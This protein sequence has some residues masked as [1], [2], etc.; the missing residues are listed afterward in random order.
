MTVNNHVLKC[1]GKIYSFGYRYAAVKVACRISC[2][3][4]HFTKLVVNMNNRRHFFRGGGYCRVR[5]VEIIKTGYR[6]TTLMEDRKALMFLVLD[7]Y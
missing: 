5:L 7:L 2:R 1:L 6:D 4:V 3:Y